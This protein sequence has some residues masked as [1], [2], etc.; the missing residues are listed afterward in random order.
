VRLAA[1]AGAAAAVLAANPSLLLGL[2]GFL[3]SGPWRT[4]ASVGV[5]LIV[6]AIPT[7]IRLIPQPKVA[8]KV[9]R[10]A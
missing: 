1:L 9:A 4:V 2:I 3:P 10:D 5:G 8:E 7:L 6:F